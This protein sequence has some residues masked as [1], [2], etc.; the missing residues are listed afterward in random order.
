MAV[1]VKGMTYNAN[2]AMV[3]YDNFMPCG[4]TW[5]DRVSK[6]GNNNKKGLKYIMSPVHFY[7]SLFQ[8]THHINR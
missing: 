5:S 3:K 7:A 4:M 2:A 6:Y 1:L 8:W